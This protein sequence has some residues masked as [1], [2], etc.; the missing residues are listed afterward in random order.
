MS[1]LYWPPDKQMKRMKTFFPLSQ[2]V[3]RVDDRRLFSL[4]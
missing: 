4:R 2:G 1:K 3:P